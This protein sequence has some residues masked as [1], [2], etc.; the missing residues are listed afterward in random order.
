MVNRQVISI[1][2]ASFCILISGEV[3]TYRA[4]TN[5][6]S[7]L[8]ETDRVSEDRAIDLLES[9]FDHIAAQDKLSFE[10]DIT[11]DTVLVTGEKI[12]YSAYQFITARRPDR[13]FIDYVGD[14]KVS[15]TFYDGETFTQI[16]PDAGLYVTEEA[17]STIDEL[18]LDLEER[19][20]VAIPLSTFV[21][22]DP[23]ER[24]SN[25]INSS[26]YLGTSYVNRVPS[27]HLLFITDEKDFQVW[28]SEEDTPLVQKL[29]I[30]YK[31]LSGQPQYTAVLSNWNFDPDADDELFTFNPAE[32]DRQVDFLPQE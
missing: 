28:V 29:V 11:Y 32:A 7:T 27:H 25:S 20:G 21:L 5:V 26:T 16:D 14:L 17:L 24:L 8:E 6:E 1:F 31:G 30:T 2:L 9:A 3:A 15:Q 18:V 12:Q 10:L 19:R 4:Q 23:I 22:S 13:L